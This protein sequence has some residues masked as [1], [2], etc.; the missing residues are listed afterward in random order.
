MGKKKYAET[1]KLI[2]HQNEL[3]EFADGMFDHCLEGV[4]KK[5]IS[6]IEVLGTLESMKYTLLLASHDAA[7]AEAERNREAEDDGFSSAIG[8]LIE[9]LESIY[10]DE[11]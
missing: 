8:E 4:N 1:T 10:G 5:H 6:V 9:I 2:D 11:G 3:K 7:S